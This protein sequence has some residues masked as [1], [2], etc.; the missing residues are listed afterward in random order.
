VALFKVLS[1]HLPGRTGENHEN[2][3]QDSLSP[4]RDLN[5]GPSEYEAGVLT[6]RWPVMY[7]IHI[8]IITVAKTIMEYKITSDFH[9]IADIVISC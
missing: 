7:Q 6:T 9:L 3:S 8:L 2:L 1:Q 4:D 5:P